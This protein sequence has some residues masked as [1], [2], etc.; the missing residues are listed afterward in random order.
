MKSLFGFQETLEV[1]TN[2]VPKI[3]HNSNDAQRINHKDAKKK[4][5][6]VVFCI[7]SAVDV[8]N[9]NRI[10]HDEYANEALDILIKYYE[11]GEKVN[12][13]KLQTL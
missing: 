5:S 2:G 11:G 10:S 1:V 7:Q 3:S 13:V 9:F 4:D 12:G 8:G 6:K